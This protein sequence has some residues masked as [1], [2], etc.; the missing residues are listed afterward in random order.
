M[1][2]RDHARRRRGLPHDPMPTAS[3]I[4]A[5]AP[6]AVWIEASEAQ[7][8]E[9]HRWRIFFRLIGR[10][11]LKSDRAL[12]QGLA[13]SSALAYTP[14]RRTQKPCSNRAL[15]IQEK[16]FGPDHLK[17]S[18]TLNSLAIVQR[19]NNKPAET[20]VSFRRAL[21]I[22]EKRTGPDNRTVAVRL[23]NL[24]SLLISMNRS[25]EA[26]ALLRRALSIT[27]KALGPDH[28]HRPVGWRPCLGLCI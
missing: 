10:S 17:L 24:A 7:R 1:P 14:S 25:A 27:E 28:P 21:A 5:T 6:S 16:T 18:P 26:E 13:M 19:L 9:L 15:A 8:D 20:E 4:S 23:T 2:I 3:L 12:F 22:Q 11:V